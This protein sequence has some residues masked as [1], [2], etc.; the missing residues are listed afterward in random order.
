MIIERLEKD[1]QRY[2]AELKLKSTMQEARLCDNC[3]NEV[4]PAELDQEYQHSTAVD[5]ETKNLLDAR[6]ESLLMESTT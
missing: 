5:I 6:N 4:E 2:K 1:V 3:M